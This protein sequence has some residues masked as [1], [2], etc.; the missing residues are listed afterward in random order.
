MNL[1]RFGL[2]LLAD[3]EGQTLSEYA[4]ILFLIMLVA[5][6]ALTLFGQSVSALITNFVN[7]F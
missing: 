3:E 6:G 7:A 2:Y 1:I 4:L 5:V